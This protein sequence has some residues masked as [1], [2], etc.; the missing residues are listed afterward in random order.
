M[1]KRSYKQNCALAHAVDIVGERWSFLLIRELMLGPRRYGELNKSLKGMGTNLLISRLRELEAAGIVAKSA[2]NGPSRYELTQRGAALEPTVLALV[3]WGMQHAHR[4][5]PNFTHRPEW[6]LVAL[7]AAFDKR[8]APADTS[9]EFAA[10]GWHGW[11][12]IRQSRLEIGLGKARSPDV[13]VYG[14]VQDLFRPTGTIKP[15]LSGNVE[16]LQR[17]MAAFSD[18][19]TA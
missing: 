4:S 11:A 12:E 6:D 2:E 15:R 7:K 18:A 5:E 14:N 9:V 8:N 1:A 13:V 17:F 19:G 16:K 3:R 10:E